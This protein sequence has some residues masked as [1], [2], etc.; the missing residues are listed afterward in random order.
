MAILEAATSASYDVAHPS[1][2]LAAMQPARWMERH[3]TANTAGNTLTVQAGGATSGATD[4][5][6]GD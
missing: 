4:K 5:A 1:T 2:R 3:T 6:G